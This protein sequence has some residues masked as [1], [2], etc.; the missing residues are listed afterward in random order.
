M[1]SVALASPATFSAVVYGV[2]W[3]L[4]ASDCAAWTVKLFKV[5]DRTILQTICHVIWAPTA[6]QASATLLAA[7]T[8]PVPRALFVYA[9]HMHTYRM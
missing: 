7:V 2:P 1:D 9:L 6:L 4:P 5:Y 3:V 8:E